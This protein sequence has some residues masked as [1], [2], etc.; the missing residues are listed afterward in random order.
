MDAT[1]RRLGSLVEWV[2]AACCVAAGSAMLLV[3]A[4]E[5]RSVRPVVPVIAEEAAPDLSNPGIPAAAVSVPILLLHNQQ[6]V[7]VGATLDD[8]T[9][10][11]ASSRLV[12]ESLDETAGR[13]R[14][15]RSYNDAGRQFVVVFEARPEGNV[16]LSAIYI[17]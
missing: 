1:R 9:R 11:L 10:R 8:V 15:T 17:R 16:Q 2:L 6:V 3:A 12:S 7:R 5:F 13:P 14:I 4:S